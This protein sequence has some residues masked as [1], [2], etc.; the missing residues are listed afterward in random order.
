[1]IIPEDVCSI[2]K[3]ARDILIAQHEKRCVDKRPSDAR[4]IQVY[5]S[6]QML[7]SKL[8]TQEHYET[9]RALYIS[10]LRN[11]SNTL[12]LGDQTLPTRVSPPTGPTH[13]LP[14]HTVHAAHTAHRV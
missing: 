1:M 11:A 6:K 9:A 14:P 12:G 10:A 8:L 4:L 13:V 3:T 5:M 2:V 7:A